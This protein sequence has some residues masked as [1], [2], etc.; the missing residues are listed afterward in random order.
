[1]I[2]LQCA[3]VPFFTKAPHCNLSIHTITLNVFYQINV[4]ASFF[5]QHTPQNTRRNTSTHFLS[6][7]FAS[8]VCVCLVLFLRLFL[9][10]VR[11][12][13][14]F[15]TRHF[16][17]CAFVSPLCPL[18]YLRVVPVTP[19]LRASSSPYPSPLCLLSSV[20]PCLLIYRF[21]DSSP[22]QQSPPCAPLLHLSPSHRS[23]PKPSSMSLFSPVL[24]PLHVSLKLCLL[25]SLPLRSLPVELYHFLAA[26]L[27]TCSPAPHPIFAPIQVLLSFLYCFRVVTFKAV[28]I[29]S[30]PVTLFDSKYV[31]SSLEVI[32]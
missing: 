1:M 3:L 7:V 17:T 10:G 31:V 26:P 22:P 11:F 32:L 21:C 20:H 24:P 25:A 13:P 23:P 28:S 4:K 2:P 30:Y 19:P 15:R 14:S 29:T 8:A 16:A 27:F 9:L 5:L 12:F 18:V 6:F